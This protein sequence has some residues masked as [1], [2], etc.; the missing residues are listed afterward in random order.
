MAIGVVAILII[1]FAGFLW[2]RRIVPSQ[3]PQGLAFTTSFAAALLLISSSIGFG[4]QKGPALLSEARWT[5]GVIW[6][7]VGLG[8]A[9]L[10]AAV[11]CWRRALK[12]ADRRLGRT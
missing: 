7:Q 2:H 8:V 4:L 10:V 9:F 11:I 6:P 5:N 12:D 3:S 1:L